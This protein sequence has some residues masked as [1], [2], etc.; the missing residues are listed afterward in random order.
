MQ[1]L[2]S[3][4]QNKQQAFP[5]YSHY[6]LQSRSGLLNSPLFS[7]LSLA[8]FLLDPN[9]WERRT[10]SLKGNRLDLRYDYH[11][12]II[13]LFTIMTFQ[14]LRLRFTSPTFSHER[15]KV[16]SL[17]CLGR[18][19]ILD[20]IGRKNVGKFWF[21]ATLRC[22]CFKTIDIKYRH[23]RTLGEHFSEFLSILHF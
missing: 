14:Q 3:C 21:S 2:T 23:Y 20:R 1:D 13:W 22:R 5:C 10:Q 12:K 18:V 9:I 4:M 6:N 19:Q 17:T 15:R 16:C 7:S 11:G 8:F